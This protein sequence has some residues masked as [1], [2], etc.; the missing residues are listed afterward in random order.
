MYDNSLYVNPAI[1]NFWLN[2]KKNDAPFHPFK[3]NKNLVFFGDILSRKSFDFISERINKL[4]I[5]YDEESVTKCFIDIIKAERNHTSELTNLAIKAV[6]EAFDV[7]EDLLC[8]KLNEESNVDVNQTEKRFNKNFNY[9]NLSIH[10]KN[11]INK[12]ILLNC[13]IQGSSIHSFYTLHHLVKNDLDKINKNLV[14]LYDNFS[15]ASVRSYYSVNYSNILNQNFSIESVL[16]SCKVEYDEDNPKVIAHAKSFPVLCQELVKGSIETV[17]LHGLKDLSKEELEQ[18]YY[19]ADQLQDEPR[20]I[21]IS[22]E[23][24]REFLEF[25]KFYA[26]EINK[27]SIP[28]LVMKISNLDPDEIQNF[29]E[30]LL[31]KDYQD[32]LSFV[33]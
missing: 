27:I 33:A 6:S 3:K 15:V 12:R 30:F 4:Q 21:Q 11:Q 18:I 23:I 28:E 13:L 29:F 1:R 16:G 5:K 19:F 26:S 25:N 8:A 24:W 32:A 2:L 17:C 10:T 31:Q 9:N 20:Y 7:P 22:S 14:S